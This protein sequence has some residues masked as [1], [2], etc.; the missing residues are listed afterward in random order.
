MWFGPKSSPPCGR[1]ASP[2]FSAIS[3]ALAKVDVSPA[4]SSLDSPNPI[5]FPFVFPAYLLASLARHL[6]SSGCRIREAATIMPTSIP[7]VCADIL[8][9][10]H[11]ISRAGVSPPTCGAYEVGST[12]ISSLCEPS[13][14]SSST[15]SSIIRRIIVSVRTNARAVSYAR[16]NLNHPL[17][18][19]GT[20]IASFSVKYDG[21][22]ICFSSASSSRVFSRIAPVK[23]RCRC[24][25]GSF[26]R[27]LIFFFRVLLFAS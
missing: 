1:H 20:F 6:A 7:C 10:S 12:C 16:W 24:A 18:S 17:L 2:L 27:S 3:K 11:I 4:L 25:F 9:W 5:T 15:A 19:A 22:R 8:A 14:L 21:S 13:F 23:C 26:D